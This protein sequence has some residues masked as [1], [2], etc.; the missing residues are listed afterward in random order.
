[1]FVGNT[2][3]SGSTSIFLLENLSLDSPLYWSWP[4]DSTKGSPESK[5]SMSGCSSIVTLLGLE[6]LEVFEVLLGQFGLPCE[7]VERGV[8]AV[9]RV[10]GQLGVGAAEGWG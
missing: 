2:S 5:S 7:H 9:G 10:G 1:M 4:W 3:I 8:A 6:V